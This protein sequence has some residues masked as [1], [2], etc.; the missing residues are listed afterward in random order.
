MDKQAAMRLIPSIES[1]L[2]NAAGTE[3]FSELSHAVLAELFRKVVQ[4]VRHEILSGS[5]AGKDTSQRMQ[6]AIVER[7]IQE[8]NR[9]LQPRLRRVVNATG[10]ILHTNLGRAPL[11][12]RARQ[13]V[14]A[15]MQG[16][17]NLEYDL[18]KGARKRQAAPYR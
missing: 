4:M 5:A 15:V 1:L 2:E 7:A 9:L 13:Q 8:Q 12:E 6:D 18:E 17:S 14:N 10:I 3:A 16:Y 11:G